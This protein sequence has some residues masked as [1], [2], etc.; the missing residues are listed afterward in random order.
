MKEHKKCIMIIIA[1]C[2][3][4]SGCL[5]SSNDEGIPA[6]ALTH[7]ITEDNSKI[8]QTEIGDEGDDKNTAVN[9]YMDNTGSMQGF[10]FDTDWSVNPSEEYTHFMTVLRDMGTVSGFDDTSCYYIGEDAAGN[11]EWQKRP[12]ELISLLSNKNMYYSWEDQNGD[13]TAGGPLTLLNLDNYMSLEKDTISVIVTDLAEQNLKNTTFGETV[14]NYCEA[15]DYEAYLYCFRFKYNGTVGVPNPDN[16]SEIIEEEVRGEGATR[17]YYMIVMG[18]Q[19]ALDRYIKKLNGKF[20]DNDLN[21]GED[22]YFESTIAEQSIT[23]PEQVDEITISDVTFAECIVDGNKEYKAYDDEDYIRNHPDGISKNLIWIEDAQSIFEE[24]DKKINDGVTGFK[25]EYGNSTD[26]MWWLT[27][28]IPEKKSEGIEYSW[29]ADVYYLDSTENL[30]RDVDTENENAEVS[31]E[32]ILN[33]NPSIEI[34]YGSEHGGNRRI[35]VAKKDASKDDDFEAILVMLKGTYTGQET[36]ITY[37]KTVPDWIGM[38]DARS[39]AE[40]FTKT[41]NLKGFYEALFDVADDENEIVEV[42]TNT[43]EYITIPIV[44]IK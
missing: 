2:M 24:T 10:I 39:K 29:Y 42:N 8:T 37:L 25:I 41:Y 18:P 11:R 6:S 21:E 5:G 14:R 43:E 38:F 3:A 32:W 9:Y 40:S 12:E 15:N 30:N 23:I 26:K 4:L 17:P 13:V 31:Y 7:Q 35:V 16:L 36:V 27:V 44:I 1:V 33:N 19:K 28:T 34:D 20:S 22:Y